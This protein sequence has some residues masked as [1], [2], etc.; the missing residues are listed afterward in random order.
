MRV[1]KKGQWVKGLPYK[2]DD[3]SLNPQ[4]LIR[5]RPFRAHTC[6]PS[7]PPREMGAKQGVWK[8][9]LVVAAAN[10]KRCSRRQGGR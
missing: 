1:G 4:N 6:Y 5:V 3:L 9:Q 10:I 7:A 8:L 2:P